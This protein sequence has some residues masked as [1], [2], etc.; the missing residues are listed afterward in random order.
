MK[1]ASRG[2]RHFRIEFA[3]RAVNDLDSIYRYSLENWGERT[4][5]RYMRGFDQA[6]ELIS[7]SSD[8]LEKDDRLS[9]LLLFSRVQK[10]LLVCYRHEP[11]ILVLAVPHVSMDLPVHFREL[12]PTLSAEIRLVQK[13]LD[14]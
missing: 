4:A 12:E 5:L 1:R 8:V 6:L 7:A 2:A 9:E 10:H 11:V 14:G 3:A 13:K